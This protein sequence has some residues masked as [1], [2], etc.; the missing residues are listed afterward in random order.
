MILIEEVGKQIEEE[1]V[2]FIGIAALM[3]IVSGSVG[4]FTFPMGL[5]MGLKSA[6][7]LAKNGPVFPVYMN[8]PFPAHSQFHLFAVTNPREVLQGGRMSFQ[9]KG[10]YEFDAWLRRDDVEFKREGEKLSFNGG[11]ILVPKETKEPDWD[12]K[13]WLINPI[14]PSTAMQVRS[15]V[16]DRVPF[17]RITEPVV[18]NAVNLLL[19]QYKERLLMRTTPRSILMGRRVNMLDAISTLA[20]R[21]GLETLVPP[22]PPQNTFGLAFV[23]NHTI[24]IGRA[25]V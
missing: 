23:Q 19:E 21:F 14:I 10:P 7:N 17:K 11:R 24:E 16:I 4:Y 22:G 6:V 9:L 20:A 8:P 12:E 18:F 3:A 5:S 1:M 25:H 15:M 13:M 2:S